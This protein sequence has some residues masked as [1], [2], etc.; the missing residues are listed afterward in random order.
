MIIDRGNDF[1]PSMQKKLDSYGSEMWL[2]RDHADIGTTRAMNSYRGDHRRFRE[3][4][5]SF[6]QRPMLMHLDR[7]FC[8]TTPRIRLTPQDLTKT[9]L[10]Q[11]ITLHFICSPSRAHSILSEIRE[12]DVWSP[13][14]I[15]EPIPVRGAF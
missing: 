4:L 15:Y 8:Y 14:T 2:F 3:D 5:Y 10:A 12:I 6:P 13:I 1:P 9:Q 7:S 11:P